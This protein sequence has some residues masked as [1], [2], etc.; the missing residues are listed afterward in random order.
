MKSGK[1]ENSSPGGEK[2]CIYRGEVTDIE[3]G[4]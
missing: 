3:E 2:M 4:L 1:I